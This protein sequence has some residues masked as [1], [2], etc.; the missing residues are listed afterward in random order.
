MN[1]LNMGPQKNW[2]VPIKL[3]ICAMKKKV[4]SKPM[5]EIL[6]R[7]ASPEIEIILMWECL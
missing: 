2:K 7:L 5:K 3:G 1:S 6:S 4:E